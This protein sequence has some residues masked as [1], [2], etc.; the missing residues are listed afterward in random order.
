MN[1]SLFFL[2]IHIHIFS[3]EKGRKYFPDK[4]L[5]ICDHEPFGGKMYVVA[6]IAYCFYIVLLVT[7]QKTFKEILSKQKTFS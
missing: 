3:L 5:I 2:S 4:F 7:K 1:N 6:L